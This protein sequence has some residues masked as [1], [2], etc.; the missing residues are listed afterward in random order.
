MREIAGQEVVMQTTASHGHEH[1]EQRNVEIVRECMEIF[2]HSGARQRTNR[3]TPVRPG[4][5]LIAPTGR[6]A[7]ADRVC[8]RYT[9]TFVTAV[10]SA[11]PQGCD[12]RNRLAAVAVARYRAVVVTAASNVAIDAIG[13]HMRRVATAMI[14]TVQARH[15]SRRREHQ[16]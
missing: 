11:T 1:D 3:C 12:P 8:L 14:Q 7:K 16:P 10:G 4:R 9:L 15:G 13:S 5:S 6:F 2:L